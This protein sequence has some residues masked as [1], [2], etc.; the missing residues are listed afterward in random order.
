[1]LTPADVTAIR[2]SMDSY[3]RVV[4]A[5]DYTKLAAFFT[6]DAVVNPP[7]EP[8]I[9]GRAAILAWHQKLP[10]ITQFE[11]TLTRIEGRGDLAFV[12]GATALRFEPPGEPVALTQTGKFLEMRR[13][14]AD[15][16]WLIAIDFFSS[17]AP[18]LP[19]SAAR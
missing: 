12:Y 3:V 16:R 18:P 4:L 5:G 9:E 11:V 13:R 15:G 2:E 19:A 7:L 10:P 17:N 14:Q 8:P 6:E 1:M